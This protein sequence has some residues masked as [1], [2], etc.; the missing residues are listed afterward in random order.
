[1]LPGG[2]DG[3]VYKSHCVLLD[4]FLC[5]NCYY[6]F[7]QNASDGAQYSSGDGWMGNRELLGG[8]MVLLLV[9]FAEG[10]EGCL[11]V[12]ADR[13]Y[14]RTSGRVAIVVKRYGRARGFHDCVRRAPRVNCEINLG[15]PCS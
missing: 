14:L 11:S 6:F 12:G 3:V 4:V 1:M 2:G 10:M 13:S 8:G 9:S 7:A 15:P 5:L